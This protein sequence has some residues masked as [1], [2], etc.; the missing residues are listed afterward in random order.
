MTVTIQSL[1]DEGIMVELGQQALL[2][3]VASR[4]MSALAAIKTRF[5]YW[6]GWMILPRIS[7]TCK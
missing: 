7:R 1:E 3:V 4:G 6:G 5:R 2:G